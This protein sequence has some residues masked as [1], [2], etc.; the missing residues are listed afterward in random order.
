MVDNLLYKVRIYLPLDMI[1]L[2]SVPVSKFDDCWLNS[3]DKEI[4][5]LS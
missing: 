3:K 1:E 5:K 2:K 4:F